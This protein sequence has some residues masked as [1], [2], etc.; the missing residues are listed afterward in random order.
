[1]PWE[2]G[3]HPSLRGKGSNGGGPC[4]DGIGRRGGRGASIRMK[5]ELID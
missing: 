2:V 1:M 4:K 3:I 5:S